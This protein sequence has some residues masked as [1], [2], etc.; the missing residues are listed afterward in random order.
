MESDRHVTTRNGI[1]NLT[2]AA[3]GIVDLHSDF[4]EANVEYSVDW[5]QYFGSSVVD[6]QLS[7]QDG[8]AV[9][10]GVGAEAQLIHYLDSITMRF[11]WMKRLNQLNR[12]FTVRERHSASFRMN[13]SLDG[14]ISG[15][16]A[17][18]WYCWC[19]EATS[20]R[21]GCWDS[22]RNEGGAMIGMLAADWGF[23]PVMPVKPVFIDAARLTASYGVPVAPTDE[24][25]TA[26]ALKGRL[27]FSPIEP[28]WDAVC[29]VSCEVSLG[30]RFRP[31]VNLSTSDVVDDDG[32]GDFRVAMKNE[33][34]WCRS[35]R[36]G[37]TNQCLW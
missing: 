2:A 25:L 17:R 36:Q 1:E 33:Y 19:A 10:V 35:C 27:F 4:L 15:W 26:D 11:R 37:R 23:E 22:L 30:T 21:I 9:G 14:L 20:T 12:I 8:N 32:V 13:S 5:Q 6:G 28:W 31:C 29:C 3:A 18:C 24:R 34:L 16:T 7:E